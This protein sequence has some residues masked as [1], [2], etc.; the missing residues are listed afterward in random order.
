MCVC[1]W[2]SVLTLSTLQRLHVDTPA[3]RQHPVAPAVAVL[4]IHHGAQGV[5]RLKQLLPDL[6]LLLQW[7]R[8][9]RQCQCERVCG[10]CLCVLVRR[11]QG[12]NEC[13][14]AAPST[15]ALSVPDKRPVSVCVCVC[16]W[17]LARSLPYLSVRCTEGRYLLIQCDHVRG[18]L[19]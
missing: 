2:P 7:T 10:L 5:R 9:Q 12:L 11:H 19:T 18:L 4:A 17:C 8:T 3:L 6:V 14:S 13:V 1:M 15:T 16:V